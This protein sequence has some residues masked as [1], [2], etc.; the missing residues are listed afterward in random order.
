M[1]TKYLIIGNS[2]AGV[3]CIE[4]IRTQDP[5]GKIVVLSDEAFLNYSKP[6]ISYYLG[7]KVKKDQM[8][9]RDCDFY[10][11]HNVELFLDTK[12][13]KI[14]VEKKEVYCGKGKIHFDKLLIACG[15]KPIIPPIEGLNEAKEGIFTF[16]Q[17]NDAENLINYIQKNNIKRAVILGGGLIGLKCSEGL[18]ERGLKITI[19]ELADRIL[20]NTFDKEASEILEGALD[21]MG[22][23]IVKE[24]TI[25][26][27]KSQRSKVKSVV[28]KSGGEIPTELLVIAIGVRP[29][30]ELLKGTSIKYDRGIIVN[31]FLQTNIPDIYAA[32]DVALSRD[33]LSNEPSIIPIWPVASYQGRIAGFNMAGKKQGY[34]GMFPMNSVELAGI[35][36]IS[37]GVTN[38]AENKGY[39]ALRSKER[40]F[41]RKIVLKDNQIKGA[42]FL[43]KIERA[44][45]FLGLIK[46]GVDVSAFKEKLLSDDF[47]LLILPKEYRKHIVVGEGIEV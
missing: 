6:L 17:L 25:V 18:L 29:N 33:L 41:Y 20:A 32:G 35:P 27:V 16:T 44:G 42:I 23:K 30:I 2:S 11:K 9:F 46:N 31:E 8:Q 10:K 4:G 40:G 38:P 5:K 12:G 3:H 1:K 34:K 47:G 19:V 36:S 15:G 28:L 14:D 43:G 22:C 26:K 39:E 13:E 21:K 7:N 24:D 45:I 37:F